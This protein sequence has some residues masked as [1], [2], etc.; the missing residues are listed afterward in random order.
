MSSA[1]SPLPGCLPKAVIFDWDNTLVETWPVIHDALNHTLRAFDKPEWSLDETR[2]RVRKSM[3]D[4]F[5]ALFGDDWQRAGE[6]FYQRY[7]EIHAQNL[8]MAPGAAPLLK[9][10]YGAGIYLSVVSNKKGHYLRKEADA[11]DW[12]Q[13][14]G[15]M[16]GASDAERDKPAIDPILM[17]LAPSGRKPGADVWFIGDA[18]IDME[19]AHAGGCYPVLLRPDPPQ[20]GEFVEYPPA[21]HFPTCDSLCKFCIT[22]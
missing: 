1:H 4:S 17:A 12:R 19:C 22:L 5:P 15:A 20:N 21:A 6:V 3:R 13:Y 2:Q 18:D 14:F 7:E 8:V 11:L 9:R 10:L 16:I